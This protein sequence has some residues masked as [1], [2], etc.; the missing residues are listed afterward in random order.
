[1]VDIIP[2]INGTSLIVETSS[3]LLNRFEWLYTVLKGVGIILAI[4][5]IYLIFKAYTDGKM[6][7]RVKNIEDVLLVVS[8]K[9]DVLIE[10]KGIKTKKSGKKRKV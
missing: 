6:K 9:L 3:V 1:M 4:Y 2:S 5:L 8:N 10:E 7:R